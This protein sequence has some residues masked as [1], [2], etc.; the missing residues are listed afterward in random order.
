MGLFG[1]S[2]LLGKQLGSIASLTDF[3]TQQFDTDLAGTLL[4][5]D[6]PQFGGISKLSG[7]S[8][9]FGQQDPLTGSFGAPQKLRGAELAPGA[10]AWGSPAPSMGTGGSSPNVGGDWAGVERWSAQIDQAAATYG[11]PAGLIKAVMKLESGG[12]PEAAGAAGV[13]GPM[14][15]NSDAWGYGPWSTDP[16]ANIMKGAEILS[17]YYQQYGNWRDALRHYHGIGSDGY[18]TDQQYAD[19]VLGNWDQLNNAGMGAGLGYNPGAGG[20]AGTSAV[21]SGM[22]GAGAGVPDWGEFGAESGNGLYGYGTA[23]GM[24]GTQHTGADVPLAV[25]T[26]YR[27]PMGGQVLCGGTGNGT[28]SG[29]GSCSAFNDYYGNGAGRV[30]VLLDNGAVLI[31]GHSSTSALQP[32]MRFRAGDV[33]GTSGGMNSAHIHLEARVRDASMPSGWRIVDPRSVLGEGSFGGGG[34][35]GGGGATTGGGYGFD[36]LAMIRR[37]RG[38]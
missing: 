6:Q 10:G 32:G 1:A 25:G 11:I 4:S 38:Y 5:P 12:D 8:L 34:T 7:S 28:D 22:F 37:I 26:A 33:L 20:F 9:A 35:F 15:V 27:A 19:I 21:I 18:T 36:P 31:F 24:N 29:G 2:N 13:W 3:A 16:T 30:E 23:Y 14:Q 17:S